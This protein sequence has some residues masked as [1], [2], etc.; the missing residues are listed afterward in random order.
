[1]S[2]SPRHHEDARKVWGQCLLEG[3]SPIEG[4]QWLEVSLILK[5]EKWWTLEQ[6]YRN[7]KLVQEVQKETTLRHKKRNYQYIDQKQ[8]Q[9]S[10]WLDDIFDDFLYS[11]NVFVLKNVDCRNIIWFDNTRVLLISE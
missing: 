3:G 10:F 7:H 1:M 5:V 8:T 9:K 2:G 6:W 11:Q 4:W